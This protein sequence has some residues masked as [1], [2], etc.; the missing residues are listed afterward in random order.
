MR[1]GATSRN[2]KTMPDEWKYEIFNQTIFS[3]FSSR[4]IANHTHTHKSTAVL[5]K[6]LDCGKICVFGLPKDKMKLNVALMRIG[7]S[8]RKQ[9]ISDSTQWF[10]WNLKHLI[11]RTADHQTHDENENAPKIANFWSICSHIASKRRQWACIHRIGSHVCGFFRR[12]QCPNRLHAIKRLWTNL[13]TVPKWTKHW[14]LISVCVWISICLIWTQTRAT[15]PATD[16]VV[17]PWEPV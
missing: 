12:N 13:K 8:K 10:T 11:S 2:D 15:A 16:T 4:I 3:Q 7:N 5:K 14:K 9:N 1:E 6:S 17:I